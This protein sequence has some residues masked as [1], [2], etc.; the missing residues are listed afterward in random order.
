VENIKGAALAAGFG[1]RLQPFTNHIPKAAV[2]VFSIPSLYF[3]YYH[4]EKAGI[5]KVATNIHYQKEQVEELINNAP[6][7]KLNIHQSYEPEILGS[8]GAYSKL[9]EWRDGAD[10]L[11]YNPDTVCD[12]DVRKFIDKFKDDSFIGGIAVLPT[13]PKGSKPTVWIQDGNIVGINKELPSYLNNIDPNEL[14][15]K[16]GAA[17]FYLKAEV[18]NTFPKGEPFDIIGGLVKL[19][20]EG[21]KLGSYMHDGFW[22]DIGNGPDL[23][24]Q[25]H[26]DL[27]ASLPTF[28]SVGCIEL[29]KRI[30]SKYSLDIKKNYKLFLSDLVKGDLPVSLSGTVVLGG[31]TTLEKGVSLSN[32]IS[33]GK[34]ELV[35]T[36]EISDQIRGYGEI[37]PL[38]CP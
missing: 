27:L 33:F 5:N 38:T 32:F 11:I 37:A 15:C 36:G 25:C 14:S 19:I 3:A 2:P 13:P 20:R 10:L 1:T 28:E 6:F 4:L 29:L 7:P 9:E 22:C 30:D 23:L 26:S 8:G 12:L 31:N 34:H 17:V 16:Y 24:M 21:K 18:F 35:L